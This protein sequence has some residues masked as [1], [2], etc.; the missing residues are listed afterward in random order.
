ML[1]VQGVTNVSTDVCRVPASG[2]S[3]GLLRRFF[4]G[5]VQY[6]SP[7]ALKGRRKCQAA[8][9]TNAR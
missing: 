8:M 6:L 3:N 2:L 7:L 4:D 5:A 9:L 1:S